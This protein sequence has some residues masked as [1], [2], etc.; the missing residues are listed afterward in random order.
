[1]NIHISVEM[2][3]LPNRL[4]INYLV[5]FFLVLP[6]IFFYGFVFEYSMDVALDRDAYVSIMLHPFQGREEPLLHFISYILGFLFSNPF[7]K[8]FFIQLAFFV[9]FVMTIFKFNKSYQL[10]GF[11]KVLIVL[12][13]FLSVF[14]NMMGVQ[15][16]IGYATIMFLFIVFYLNIKPS[17][18]TLP[19][20]ILP[21]LMHFG[22]VF[23]VLSYYLFYVCKINSITRFVY[24]VAITII[25]ST[26]SIKFLP[27]I[28]ES[29]GINAYYFMYLEDGIDLGRALPFSVIFF[30]LF[31]MLSIF[32][33]SKDYSENIEFWY[34][35]FGI[36]LVY[37]GLFLELYLAFK[38]L[39]PISAFLYIYIINK[40]QLSDKSNWLLTSILLLLFPLSFYMLVNQVGL[41]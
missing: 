26:V 13:V 12:L 24:I 40:I 23:A 8:L 29:I 2:R 32:F 33:F 4:R 17:M 5:G 15:L 16:R 10:S 22:I 27:F 3:M 28:L 1:M 6:V 37:I 35:N 31:S 14:S 7:F 25:V 34:G 41:V 30:L 11:N 9:L 20:F 38:M 21:C 36:V 39:V 19:I 18:K